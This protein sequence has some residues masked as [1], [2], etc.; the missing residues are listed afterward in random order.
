MIG[1]TI[2]FLVVLVLFF[3]FVLN[4]FYES[5]INSLTSNYLALLHSLENQY[6]IEFS[7]GYERLLEEFKGLN[8]E[9]ERQEY[10]AEEIFAKVK[11]I[12]QRTYPMLQSF[13]K[14][15]KKDLEE[16][17]Y[18]SVLESYLV[19]NPNKVDYLI[20]NIYFDDYYTKI[21]L[22]KLNDKIIAV[23]VNTP[24][25]LRIFETFLNLKSYNKFIE[26]INLFTISRNQI[27]VIHQ[28]KQT[29]KVGENEV[30]KI[31]KDIYE[32]YR[33]FSTQI[34]NKFISHFKKENNIPMRQVQGT[35][36]SISDFYTVKKAD[37]VYA[38]VFLNLLTDREIGDTVIGRV[39][40]NFSQ[41]T[42]TFSITFTILMILSIFTLLVTTKKTKA[43]VKELSTTFSKLI[44][45]IKTFSYEKIFT[46]DTLD[47]ESSV[48][49]VQEI[50]EEYTKLAQELTAA[51]QEQTALTQQLEASYKEIEYAHKELEKSYLE[52]AR[53]LAIIAESYDENTGAHILRV[54]KLTSFIARKLGY[55]EDFCDKVEK[56]SP[57]HD[58][59]KVLCPKEILL[60]NGPLTTQEFEIMKLHTINGAKLIGD[61]PNLEIAKNI[62]L[63]HHEKYD[64]TGYPF[65]LSGERIPIEARIVALVDV[66]DALRSNRPYKRAFTHEESIKILL[67]GDGR[68][69]PEHFDPEVLKIFIENEKYINE[70]WNK[71]SE[72]KIN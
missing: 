16:T 62:A 48:L 40:L 41:I 8:I 54:S 19:E 35:N 20:Y 6:K 55:P 17:M 49:E 14:I 18:G 64:G 56:F 68:T 12:I 53:Q 31:Q 5:Q 72:G 57:L 38:Y 25:Y 59:G 37:K 2:T 50:L 60:K 36:S 23:K 47:F 63:Y 45:N 9:I 29:Y 67:H 15:D 21:F 7:K 44:Q 13:E 58:I 42:T 46:L 51:Y 4:Y 24:Y 28:S 71:I 10:T 43:F 39:V 3:A 32:S 70:L 22:V 26:R 61:N 66:Y 1:Y 27:S 33:K 30:K 11:D 65:G 69:K 52:F 34:A